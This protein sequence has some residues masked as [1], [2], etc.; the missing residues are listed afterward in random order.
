MGRD[1]RPISCGS[2]VRGARRAKSTR[3]PRL[4]WVRLGCFDWTQ[5]RLAKPSV[6]RRV[7]KR[8][9]GIRCHDGPK[10][11]QRV[12]SSFPSGSSKTNTEN[13]A[14]KR[15]GRGQLLSA[16]VLVMSSPEGMSGAPDRRHQAK[17]EVT[18]VFIHSGGMGPVKERTRSPVNFEFAPGFCGVASLEGGLIKMLLGCL[19]YSHW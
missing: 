4:S 3:S 5:S 15:A 10:K 9:P 17:G 19:T 7:S 13:H 2:C 1:R 12:R 8:H 6:A 14:G 18:A 16:K 11:R